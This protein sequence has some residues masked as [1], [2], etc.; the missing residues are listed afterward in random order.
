MQQE[1]IDISSDQLSKLHFEQTVNSGKD[2]RETV[3]KKLQASMIRPLK[4]RQPL[5]ITFET[6]RGFFQ[7]S[8]PLISFSKDFMTVK[9]GYT[10]PICSVIKVV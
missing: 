6:D 10:I 8:S 2:I 7:I 5:N 4:K 3:V 1:V 9:G